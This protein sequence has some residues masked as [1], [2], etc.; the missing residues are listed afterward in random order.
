ML[1]EVVVN[2]DEPEIYQPRTSLRAPL[3]TAVKM[4]ANER[5]FLKTRQ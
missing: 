5:E 1:F 3:A 4:D 2:H